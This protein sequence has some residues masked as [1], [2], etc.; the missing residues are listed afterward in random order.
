MSS[1]PQAPGVERRRQL[2]LQRR[3][4]RLRNVWR[5][6]V[7]SAAAAGLGYGLLRQGWTLSSPSQVEI[8][9]SE[10]VSREQA[11]AAA[12]LR[13]PLPLLNL[14]PRLVRSELLEALP[15]EQVAVQR[16][17]LPPVFASSWWTA[18]WWHGPSDARPRVPNRAISTGWGTGSAAAS[19]PWDPALPS[20]KRPSGC[21]DGRTVSEPPWWRSWSA[22]TTWAA[23]SS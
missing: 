3:Q 22:A 6:L 12:E 5:L 23:R 10:R 1:A 2:R 21:R 8:S 11:I 13:F 17:I 19:R 16:L 20:R 15:V 4:E 18:R 7:F 14:D 9:G